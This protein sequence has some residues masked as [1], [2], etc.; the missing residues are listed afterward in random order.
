[1]GPR[2]KERE[3]SPATPR[4]EPEKRSESNRSAVTPFSPGESQ[5]SSESF[6]AP[7]KD[8]DSCNGSDKA[9]RSTRTSAVPPELYEAEAAPSSPAPE[10]D[11]GC[12]GGLRRISSGGL[13]RISSGASL[14]STG[15]TGVAQKVSMGATDIAKKVS[16]GAAGATTR[17]TGAIRR[18]TG[19]VKLTEAVAEEQA[20]RRSLEEKRAELAEALL[21]G[22]AAI[23]AAEAAVERAV[24]DL[25]LREAEWEK[26]RDA[27]RKA[28]Q[29]K[30][31]IPMSDHGHDLP[32]HGGH[33]DHGHGHGHGDHDDVLH[34][35][36][37][38]LEHRWIEK[39]GFGVAERV[40]AHAADSLAERMAEYGTEY[41][42]E[43]GAEHLATQALEKA[44]EGAASHMLI[45]VMGE[46]MRMG[47]ATAIHALK[48]L[49]VLVPLIGML[50]VGHLAQH[51]WH[52]FKAGKGRA[53]L[54]YLL[55]VIGDWIDIAVHVFVV[56]AGLVEG[57]NIA[58]VDH[59]YLHEV[60]A[61]GMKA[62]IFACLSVMCG[63]ILSA[64]A[65]RAL[66]AAKKAPRPTVVAVAEP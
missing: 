10:A 32:G 34:G 13:T 9:S 17:A 63:E 50:F 6:N 31:G 44:S 64:R 61:Y 36:K 21:S 55:A 15:A 57:L 19:K 14:L 26:A 18:M 28:F 52:S 2:H 56:Y 43:R 58:H 3:K 16:S 29:A 65:A 22:P 7:G 53:K 39:T 37:H 51:D 60:E 1:L 47:E 5:S 42:I 12:S 25:Q 54:F 35:A 48:A 11:G 30:F 20:A 38:Q 40:V 8:D 45:R 27:A 62:A 59:H 23:A 33:G 66:Q 46:T 41:M 4:N 49:R 24:A